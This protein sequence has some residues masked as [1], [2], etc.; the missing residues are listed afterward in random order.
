MDFKECREKDIAS[1]K[2]LSNRISKLKSRV[3]SF[4][5]KLSDLEE[6]LKLQVDLS[7]IKQRHRLQ[8]LEY[9]KT[10]AAQKEFGDFQDL[11]PLN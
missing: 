6:R 2:K 7:K 3:S 1:L 4:G 11:G 10:L 9:N 8:W 5:Q